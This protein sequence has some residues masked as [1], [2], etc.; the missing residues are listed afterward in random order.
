MEQVKTVNDFKEL[1]SV[2]KEYTKEQPDGTEIWFRGQNDC[3]YGLVPSLFRYKK[4]EEKERELYETYRK[5]SYKLS[6]ARQN[7]WELLIDMQHYAIP[8]RILDWSEN[9]GVALFFAITNHAD[10][11][12][13]IFLLNPYKLNIYS[14]KQIFLMSLLKTNIFLMKMFI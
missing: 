8:T 13:A 3:K 14:K 11:D 7:D 2:I 12:V 4:G 5:F 1:I 10:N 9:L 6:F